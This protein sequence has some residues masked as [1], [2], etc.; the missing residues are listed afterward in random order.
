MF[1]SR[2]P[3]LEHVS[4]KR[5]AGPGEIYDVTYDSTPVGAVE[6]VADGWIV[7]YQGRVIPHFET[8]HSGIGWLIQRAE[9]RAANRARRE[10]RDVV[11]GSRTRPRPGT[12]E[13]GTY[14]MRVRPEPGEPFQVVRVERED[15]DPARDILGVDPG[16]RPYYRG[17]AKRE[18]REA[19]KAERERERRLKRLEK[20]KI[21]GVRSTF[22]SPKK[23]AEQIYNA[24]IDFYGPIQEVADPIDYV[25]DWFD[26]QEARVRGKW[27]PLKKTKRGGELYEAHRFEFHKPST[28]IDTLAYILGK[29]KTKRWEDVD[30]RAVEDYNDQLREAYLAEEAHGHG[31]E[32]W[33]SD[34]DLPLHARGLPSEEEAAKAPAAAREQYIWLEAQKEL[35]DIAERL[36]KAY[37]QNRKYIKDPAARKTIR[38]RIKEVKAWAEDPA[39]IPPWACVAR[40]VYCDFPAPWL[41]LA[42]IEAAKDRPYDPDWPLR[43][44]RSGKS[45]HALGVYPELESVATPTTVPPED[46]DLPWERVANRRNPNLRPVYEVRS[47]HGHEGLFRDRH[48]AE[49]YA[50]QLRGIGAKT[51][52]IEHARA[53]DVRIAGPKGRLTNRNGHVPKL[54]RRLMK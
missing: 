50:H 33:K 40:Q 13:T 10:Y 6:A 49:R 14:V 32:G 51:S 16:A 18:A 28:V 37:R 7:H 52:V 48:T 44:L 1:G 29:T 15:L 30:W 2:H 54:K 46:L 22:S 34:F 42:E 43:E 31:V 21:K 19:K 53:Q 4:V 5:R 17:E 24:N 35:W 20:G 27:K 26:R 47:E 12:L 39:K 3:N 41:E 9:E 25:D 38:E 36:E 8:G 23:G 45:A 11:T